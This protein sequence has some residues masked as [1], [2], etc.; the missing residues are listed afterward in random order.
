MKGIS[1]I[2]DA[3]SQRK[4]VVIDLKKI[5]KN[6]EAVHDLIDALVAESRSDDELIPWEVARKSLGKGAKP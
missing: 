2:T 3:N 4:A 6:T 1:Y 5:E